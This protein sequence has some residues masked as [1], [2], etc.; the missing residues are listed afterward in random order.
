MLED[1]VWRE[2]PSMNRARRMP[3]CAEY[4]NS[5]W[6]VGGDSEVSVERLDREAMNWHKEPDLWIYSYAANAVVH[7][8]TLYL[9]HYAGAVL[10]LNS[11]THRWE[12]AGSVDDS[13]DY[14][15]VYPAPLVSRKTI[16]C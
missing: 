12:S 3:A 14:R 13:P 16:G 6:A 15:K 11:E 7:N 4:Q 10:R 1:G 5:I 9:V 2:G 8:S